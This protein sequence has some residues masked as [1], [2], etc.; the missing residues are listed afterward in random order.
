M[1]EFIAVHP[2]AESPIDVTSSSQTQK[3]LGRARLEVITI[4]HENVYHSLSDD[5]GGIAPKWSDD[6]WPEERE[7]PKLGQFTFYSRSLN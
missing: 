6:R 3:V 2:T 4:S 1:R 5:D 7:A